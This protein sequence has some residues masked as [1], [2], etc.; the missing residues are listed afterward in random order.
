MD[1][2]TLIIVTLLAIS[3]VLNGILLFWM[4]QTEKRLRR[5]FQ[6]K[7]GA[8]LEDAI[9]TLASRAALLESK[10]TMHDATL[11]EHNSRIRRAVTSVPLSRFNPFPDVGGNQSFAL[12]LLDEDGNGVV[13]SSLYSRERMSVFAKGV[14]ARKGEQELSEE[15][16]A[17]IKASQR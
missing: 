7:K 5:L 10:T 8:D 4:R 15:E 13:V 12:S 1:K 17:I 6:G 16:S 11:A 9:E 3:L 14:K 2:I